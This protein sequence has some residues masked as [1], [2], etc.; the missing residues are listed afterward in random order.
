MAKKKVYVEYYGKWDGPE[1][2]EIAFEKV[3]SGEWDAER[4]DAWFRQVRLDA[5][6]DAN[7]DE[8]Y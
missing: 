1:A 3:K 4:F 7:A 5:E 8:S 6:R 2:A